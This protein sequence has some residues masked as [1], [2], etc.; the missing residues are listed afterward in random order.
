MKI[1]RGSNHLVVWKRVKRG[2]AARPT[3]FSPGRALPSRGSGR[4]FP[5]RRE[6][7]DPRRRC[8]P[9]DASEST[10][11]PLLPRAVL[12]PPGLRHV[13]APGG[14][15]AQEIQVTE[16]SPHGVGF[17]G[18]ASPSSQT[19]Q[20]YCSLHLAYFPRPSSLRACLVAATPG[21]NP[22][23]SPPAGHPPAHHGCRR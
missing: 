3:G 8:F 12:P 4:R 18:L 19:T 22:P 16:K 23:L 13:V 21:P 5:K 20:P 7:I 2:C 9:D 17:P 6:R 1:C 15:S 11:P 14:N 10:P